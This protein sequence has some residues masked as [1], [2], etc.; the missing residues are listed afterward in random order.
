M[1]RLVYNNKSFRIIDKFSI[2]LSST[3]V[4]FNSFRI[5]FTG[6]TIADIPYKFQEIKIIE[7]DNILFTGFVDSIKLSKM[8]MKN[9]YRELII[10]LLSPLKLA[11]KRT[12]SLIGTYTL[13]SAITRILQPLINDGFTIKDIFITDGQIT[14][15]FLLETIEN[16]MNTICL[17]RNIFWYINENKEIF[18]YSI[19]YLFGL[20]AKKVIN[21]NV[22][23]QGLLQLQPEIQNVDYA[24]AINFKNVR[25]IYPQLTNSFHQTTGYPIVAYNKQIKNGDA[26][27]FSNPIIVDEEQLRKVV[28]EGNFPTQE[29]YY[30]CLNIVVT[31]SGGSTRQYRIGLDETQG[32]A[33]YDKFVTIGNITFSD[34]ETE[35]EIILIRDTFFPNLITGFKWNYNSSARITYFRTLTGLRYTTMRF[36][37]SAEIEKLKG[38][39]SKTGQIEKTIDYEEKWTTTTQL[40]EYARSL[41]VQNSNV[42]NQIELE[43]DVNQNLKLGDI[44]TIN[45]PSFFINGNYAVKSI[46]YTYNNELKQIWKITLK[47]A[48]MLSTFIDLFRPSE[49]QAQSD[50]LNSVILSEF[51]EEQIN[52]VHEIEEV[53]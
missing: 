31:L 50:A 12:I 15:N 38:I 1:I 42:V 6:Y 16:C 43:Y 28:E 29:P 35:G 26:I 4:T 33:N 46:Q 34:D 21:E 45:A 25:L 39:I 2:K 52:E 22:E 20:P 9:E 10:T 36:M 18:V 44:V 17:K 23:E 47:N 13:S 30:D 37:Y 14:T 48:D 53:E 5:D 49:T 32:S 3:E 24:N 40:I 27:Y 51:V 7:D 41:I 19:D 8:E 11:T